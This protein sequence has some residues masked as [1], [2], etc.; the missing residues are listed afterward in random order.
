MSFKTQRTGQF[1][2][3]VPWQC[4]AVPMVIDWLVFRGGCARAVG[5]GVAPPLAVNVRNIMQPPTTFGCCLCLYILC[6]C[7]CGL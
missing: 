7:L 2:L 1:L 4:T 5:G 3:L 6:I